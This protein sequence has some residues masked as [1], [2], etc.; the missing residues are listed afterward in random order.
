MNEQSEDPSNFF[1]PGPAPTRYIRELLMKSGIE[2]TDSVPGDPYVKS[3]GQLSREE[4]L[5]ALR[6]K[7]VSMRRWELIEAGTP[8]DQAMEQAI[9]D[10]DAYIAEKNED[11][12]PIYGW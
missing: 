2:T 5:K 12:S 3:T 10:V 1:C 7:A 4:R 8:E 11:P 6:A 9:Q